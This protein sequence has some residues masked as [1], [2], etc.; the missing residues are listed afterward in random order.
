MVGEAVKFT[1]PFS[2]PGVISPP[3]CGAEDERL[4][5]GE[6]FTNFIKIFGKVL[7]RSE[8]NIMKVDDSADLYVWSIPNIL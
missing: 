3:L 6:Y 2:T 4:R 1:L 8:V 5:S 7:V